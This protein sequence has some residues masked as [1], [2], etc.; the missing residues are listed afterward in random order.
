MGRIAVRSGVSSSGKTTL[1]R[2]T[3]D[4]IGV[5]AVALSIDDLY[6]GVHSERRNDWNLFR[7]LTRVLFD[8]AGSYAREGFAVIVDTVFERP[9]CRELCVTKLRPL[10]LLL[11]RVDCSL[12][13]LVERERARAD[14]RRGLAEDQAARVH[15]GCSYDFAVDTSSS[16]P[17]ECAHAI[18][19]ALAN[20]PVERDGP[21]SS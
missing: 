21:T 1:A 14:R 5:D 7:S 18:A 15:E 13:V 19:T 4:V 9:E 17:D 16:T 11:V 6:R 10:G 12:A 2:A 3:R 8:S 20:V